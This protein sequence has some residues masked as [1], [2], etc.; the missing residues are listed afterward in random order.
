MTK[1][2]M[3][4]IQFVFYTKIVNSKGVHM[5]EIRETKLKPCPFFFFFAEIESFTAKVALFKK[6]TGKCITCKSCKCRTK[7]ML[8]EE[9]A[10]ETWNRRE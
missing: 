9:E 1:K 6:A 10:I 7:L 4:I 5:K 3:V 8:D 2:D